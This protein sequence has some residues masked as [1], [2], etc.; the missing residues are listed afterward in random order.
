[1]LGALALGLPGQVLVKALSSVF[2]AR[3]DTRTPMIAAGIGLVAALIA[4]LVFVAIGRPTGIALS[5]GLSGWISAAMLW[6]IAT[7]RGMLHVGWGEWRRLILITTSALAMGIFARLMAEFVNLSLIESR[8]MQVA[9][10]GTIIGFAIAVYA[11]CLWLT[12]I[13]RPHEWRA[14]F[15]RR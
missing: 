6:L 14:L 9:L 5:V 12:G 13:V 2:F 7:R 1:M 4:S 10:L 8:L 15:A 3:E 11:S